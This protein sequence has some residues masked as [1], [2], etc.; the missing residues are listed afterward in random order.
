MAC[1]KALK[2]RFYACFYGTWLN[3]HVSYKNA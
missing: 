2:T 3:P 1:F